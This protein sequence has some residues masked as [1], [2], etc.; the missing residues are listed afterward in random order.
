MHGVS[1]LLLLLP[2]I[3]TA[4]AAAAPA[5]VTLL[6]HAGDPATWFGSVAIALR[7]PTDPIMMVTSWVFAPEELVAYRPS[8]ANA[9][10]AWRVDTTADLT[11][12]TLY[13]G[14]SGAPLP[15]RVDSIAFWNMKPHG[16]V[17]DCALIG[18][19]SDAA[20]D[21]TGKASPNN[22]RVN[23]SS[24]CQNINGW[25]PFTRFGLSR[26]GATAIAWIQDSDENVTVYCYDGQTGAARWK[27]VFPAP[28]TERSFAVSFGA[29]ISE[30][31][32]WVT[33][34]YGIETVSPQFLYVLD[35]S[36]GALR[37]DPVP[38]KGLLQATLSPDGDYLMELMDE[39]SGA[40]SVMRFNATSHAYEVVGTV[41]PPSPPVSHGWTLGGSAFSTDGNTT[42]AGLAWFDTNLAGTSVVA[43][44]D[45]GSLS[46]PVAAVVVP[47]VDGD[48]IAVASASISCDGALCAAALW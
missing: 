7:S 32:R 31:G 47:P 2:T 41:Q 14:S 24:N 8:T 20:P 6:Q 25:V 37:C 12:Q 43:M 48:D 3:P 33:V 27:H 23:V 29:E 5:N 22:W 17:G 28:A 38:S 10:A 40:M 19:H 18:F 46:S 13:I 26:D 42:Y 9:S 35:A 44:W 4:A 11:Y 36:S 15:G 16:I 30:D 39:L 45:V 21:L 1:A 34:D